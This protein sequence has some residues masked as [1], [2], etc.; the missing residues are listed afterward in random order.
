MKT[1][2]STTALLFLLSFPAFSLPKAPDTG[3]PTGNPTPATSRP[4]AACPKVKVPVT[5]LVSNKGKDFTVSAYPTFWVYVPYTA[6]QLSNVEFILLSGNERQTLYQSTIQLTDKPGII[7][8]ALP[9]DPKYALQ[10]NQT[11]RW[12]LH[13]DCR[14]DKSA[15]P[16]VTI[17]AWV[18]RITPDPNLNAQLRSSSEPEQ[19]YRANEIWY[20][21]IDK[22]ADRYFA[23]PSNP[24]AKQ[25]WQ[26]LLQSLNLT[27]IQQEPIRGAKLTS[28]NS[29]A[30]E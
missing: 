17:D 6:D 1:I 9:N 14:P 3:T 26:Q 30:Q 13:L 5:A 15:D 2:F 4:E 19:L 27:E 29:S 12:R 8:I 11:Y 16:D 7:K 10:P 21:A 22:T 18:R 20:D 23:N 28:S 25:T 24:Q